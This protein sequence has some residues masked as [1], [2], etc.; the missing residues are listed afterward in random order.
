MQKKL[1]LEFE[2]FLLMIIEQINQKKKIS[3]LEYENGLIEMMKR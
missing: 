1:Y 2:N 3:Y